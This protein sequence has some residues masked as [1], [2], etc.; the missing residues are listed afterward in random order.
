MHWK[1]EG[2][3]ITGNGDE[4]YD[5]SAQAATHQFNL[6]GDGWLLVNESDS[7]V[8]FAVFRFSSSAVDGSGA[9]HT[10]VMHGVG[11]SGSLRECRHTYWGEGDNGG[12][13]FYPHFS[14]IT[15]A[16]DFLRRWFDGD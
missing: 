10:L 9:R 5:V 7:R 13:I 3:A 15:A 11:Y 2:L 4:V 12:Y 6:P 16:L 8:D 14:Q 1:P